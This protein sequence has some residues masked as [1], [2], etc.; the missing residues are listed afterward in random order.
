[1]MCGIG[2]PASRPCLAAFGQMQFDEIAM[3]AA[4]LDKGIDR[5]DHACALGPAA[6]GAAGQRDDGHSPLSQ[7][8]QAQVTERLP[9][10]RPWHQKH[11][12]ARHLQS[13]C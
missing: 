13:Y 9:A 12:R 11:L 3:F 2:V 5:F 1:M 10:N 4:Q 6:A 8:I 7:G